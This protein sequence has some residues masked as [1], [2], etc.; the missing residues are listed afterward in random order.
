[1]YAFF[2]GNIAMLG[3]NFTVLECGGVGYKIAT[4]RRFLENAKPGQQIV[5][6]TY[7][8]VR[9]DGMFLYGFPEEPEKEMFEKLIGIS[10]I[11]PKVALSI[12]SALSCAEV[13]SAVFAGDISAFSKVSGVGRKIAERIVLELKDKVDIGIALKHLGT[14]TT[15]SAEEEAVEALL[16]LGYPKAQAVTAV[17]NISSLAD[18]AE[19]MVVLALKRLDR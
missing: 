11:G 6:Y 13:V 7:L 12:L 3:D 14:E 18:T 15:A 17:R 5:L 1:M 4:T 2:R 8:A 9:E 16:S 19:E 10:G